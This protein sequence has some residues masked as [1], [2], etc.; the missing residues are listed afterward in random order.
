MVLHASGCVTAGRRT[1]ATTIGSNGC[2][3]EDIPGVVKF[4]HSM[5]Y[6]RWAWCCSDDICQADQGKKPCP[7]GCRANS[8]TNTGR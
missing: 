8:S 5:V 7:T 3:C 6:R 1:V 2:A 4:T